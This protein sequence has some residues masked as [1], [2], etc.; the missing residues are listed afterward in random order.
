MNDKVVKIKQTKLASRCEICHQAD[1][2]DPKT[3]EC[4]R[5]AKLNLKPINIDEAVKQYVFN[6][7]FIWT[8]I[9]TTIL[10]L[11]TIYSFYLME[12]FFEA[13]GRLFIF[14]IF[15][16]FSSFLYYQYRCRRIVWLVKNTEPVNVEFILKR[17]YHIPGV[18]RYQVQF[19]F[20]KRLLVPMDVYQPPWDT[21][22]IID[23]PHSALGYFDPNGGFVLHLDKGIIMSL[24]TPNFSSFLAKI[25]KS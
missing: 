14:L 15:L 21:S 22:Y 25:K 2:F 19:N 9:L 20:K 18:F 16:G 3:E 11:V 6:K 7:T 12:A 23:Q 24:A 10:L 5:C 17:G 13:F 1:C 4:S 8:T